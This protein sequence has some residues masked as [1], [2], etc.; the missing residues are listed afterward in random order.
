MKIKFIV[1]ETFDKVVAFIALIILLPLFLVVAVLIKIDSK[2]PVFFMQER[3]GKNGKIFKTFKFRTMIVGADEKTKGVYIDKE[4]L[5]VT[6]MG[7][8][9]RRSGVDE[10]PQVIN[11]LKGD[12]SFVG[13]RP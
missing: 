9:L 12:M 10:L 5:Y 6:R 1:K 13:P 7:K 8:L 3:A 11:V 2:G 4:N